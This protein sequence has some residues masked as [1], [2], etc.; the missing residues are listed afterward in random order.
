MQKNPE[1]NS[2]SNRPIQLNVVLSNKA[3][4]SF[5]GTNR[6]GGNCKLIAAIN[7]LLSE[8]EDSAQTSRNYRKD[9]ERWMLWCLIYQQKRFS[10]LDIDD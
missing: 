2:G 10:N 8:F 6:N 5:T 4:V 7:D 1:L 3:L 9:I